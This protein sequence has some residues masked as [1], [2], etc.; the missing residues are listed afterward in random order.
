MAAPC[1]AAATPAPDSDVR[2]MLNMLSV[3][4]QSCTK[5]AYNRSSLLGLRHSICAKNLSGVNL[6]VEPEILCELGI[7][8]QQDQGASKAADSSPT[9]GRH[10]RWRKRCGRTS[11][12]R[13]RCARPS[14]R[15]KRAGISARLKANPYRPALPSTRYPTC[16]R[17]KTKWITSDWI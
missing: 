13:R 14:K 9:T 2:F 5:I 8:H 16:A 15:G 12:R 4:L 1:T 11:M 10:W 6:A 17:W 7:L 3:P